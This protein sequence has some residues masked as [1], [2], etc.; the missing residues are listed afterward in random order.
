[1]VRRHGV[2]ATVAAAI[3]FSVILVSNLAIFAASQDRARLYV[4][5]NAEGSMSAEF[6]VLSAAGGAEALSAAAQALGSGPLACSTATRA[7]NIELGLFSYIQERAGVTVSVRT[8]AVVG[9]SAADNLSMLSPF[10][11]LAPGDL[12]IRLNLTASGSDAG[13]GVSFNKH[14]THYAHL[15]V[16][17]SAGV[18][19]CTEAV[20]L[21]E[22]AAS[23]TDPVNCTRQWVDP[24]MRA[25]VLTPA[26]EASADGFSFR[27]DYSITASAGCS[28]VFT[29]TLEQDGIQGP[30]GT[31]TLLLRGEEVASFVP[32]TP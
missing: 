9:G 25:A 15:P 23:G 4:Q 6:V 5:A 22:E 3:V 2:G 27:L 20:A 1:M 10:N 16:R 30:S 26:S 7:L 31:F 13:A 18:A 24:I 19:D 11:G 12:G 28:V 29:V 21:V 8:R 14:E 17:F 32:P